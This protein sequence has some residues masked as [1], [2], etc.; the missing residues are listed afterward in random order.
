[1]SGAALLTIT[2]AN[3]SNTMEVDLQSANKYIKII[4]AATYTGGSSPYTNRA[5]NVIL[6]GGHN[7]PP[8]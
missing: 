5:V 4:S 6:G 3:T 2:A 7:L 8:L 1:R